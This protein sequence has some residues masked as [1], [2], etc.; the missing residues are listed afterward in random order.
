MNLKYLPPQ[1]D[2]QRVVACLG[3]ISDTHMPQ[4]LAKL[5][6]SL[7]QVFADVDMIL[8]AGDVGKLTVLDELS[9]IAPVI[10]VHGN[11]DTEES[12]SELPLQQIV[13]VAGERILV[14]HG[15]FSEQIDEHIWRLVAHEWQHLL[16][17]CSRR[18]HRAG[19]RILFVG[20]LHY[21]FFTQQDD[22][23]IVN[24]GALA[25][26]S[27][28]G[29]IKRPSVAV[30]YLRDD[31]VPFVVHVD[32]TAEPKR[33]TPILD[34]QQELQE[35]L[36]QTDAPVVDEALGNMFRQIARE[37]YPLA[38][39]EV[40]AAWLRVVYPYWSGL[41]GVM[42]VEELLT[43]FEED[44]KMPAIATQTLKKIIAQNQ[45]KTS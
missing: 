19:C 28:A 25:S 33:F 20:H 22:V 40:E 39:A 31:G 7:P 9:H 5:P 45:V 37:V 17:R 15:H 29:R 14:W 38:R 34:I 35:S 11:D 21:P 18:A 43:E 27:F 4:R 36:Q 44:E 24:A 30:L 23:W 16:L 8:H 42:T 6:A 2:P 12:K 1:L 10:A 32:I 3:L 26:G 41:E 13:S